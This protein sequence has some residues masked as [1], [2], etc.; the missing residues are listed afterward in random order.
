MDVK[1]IEEK[2]LKILQVI[3]DNFSGMGFEDIIRESVDFDE[4]MHDFDTL[5]SSIGYDIKK[6]LMCYEI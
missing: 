4:E 6:I 5:Y 2:T 1:E 3:K